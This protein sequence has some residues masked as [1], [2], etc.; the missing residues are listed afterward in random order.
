MKEKSLDY[1]I[2]KLK[3]NVEKEGI[4]KTYKEK[5]YF[6]KPSLKK[7]KKVREYLHKMKKKK[8]RDH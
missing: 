7:H 6:T 3:E 4:L 8:K 5:M 2:K 1:L